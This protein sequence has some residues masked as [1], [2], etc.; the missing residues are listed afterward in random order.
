MVG[1]V[2]RELGFGPV[3]DGHRPPEHLGV[4]TGEHE[5]SSSDVHVHQADLVDDQERKY[6][7]ERKSCGV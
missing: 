5:H 2:K 7:L 6:Q 4:V 3:Q 1:E